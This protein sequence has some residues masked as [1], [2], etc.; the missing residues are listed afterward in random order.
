MNKF[1]VLIILV[2]KSGFKFQVC[3]ILH[4]HL[5]NK[6]NSLTFYTHVIKTPLEIIS[7][8]EKCEKKCSLALIELKMKNVQNLDNLP[9]NR[10]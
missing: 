4:L 6:W 7:A 1:S 10:I 2:K 3:I 5:Q 8:K 9:I